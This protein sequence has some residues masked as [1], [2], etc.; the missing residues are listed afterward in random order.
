[1]RHALLSAPLDLKVEEVDVPTLEAG[2][3]LLQVDATLLCGTDLRIYNG[4]KSKNVSL[5]TV[6]GH[7][8]PGRGVDSNRPLRE[9][10]AV[11][12]RA[13]VSPSGAW[14]ECAACR[15]GHENS[16]RNREAF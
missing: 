13:C 5:P 14:G 3:V 4:T 16:C 2:D 12:T 15:K 6:L 10:R 8:F 11:G 9:G 7:E 1:M